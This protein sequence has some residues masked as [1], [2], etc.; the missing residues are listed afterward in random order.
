MKEFTNKACHYLCIRG[1]YAHHWKYDYCLFQYPGFLC[2]RNVFETYQ[3][4]LHT[5]L[6]PI[7]PGDPNIIT[8]IFNNYD[9]VQIN[10]GKRY[11]KDHA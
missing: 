7:L 6:S 3:D 1:D 5:Q 4:L 10:K 8:K 9:M 2:F 11:V